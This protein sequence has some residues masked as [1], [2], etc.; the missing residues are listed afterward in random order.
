MNKP[1]SSS[2]THRVDSLK[3][4]QKPSEEELLRE[5]QRACF[6][7]MVEGLVGEKI[8]LEELE[9]EEYRTI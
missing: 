1:P 6:A 2:E 7:E 9:D 3:A 8:S 4:G 5:E